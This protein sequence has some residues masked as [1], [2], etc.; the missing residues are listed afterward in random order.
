MICLK[1]DRAAL[2][3]NYSLSGLHVKGAKLYL[4]FAPYETF[5]RKECMLRYHVRWG[6]G[7]LTRKV[8]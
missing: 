1:D 2:L 8:F 6:Q 3:P 4:F 5:A 7:F